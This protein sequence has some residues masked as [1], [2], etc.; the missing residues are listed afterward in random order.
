MPARFRL[1]EL[2]PCS[3]LCTR[4]QLKVH[5]PTPRSR[6]ESSALAFFACLTLRVPE[7]IAVSRGARAVQCCASRADMQRVGRREIRRPSPR[8]TAFYFRTVIASCS[9]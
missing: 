2:D 8:Y 5:P 1:R 3:H 4:T 7:I 6:V 9:C